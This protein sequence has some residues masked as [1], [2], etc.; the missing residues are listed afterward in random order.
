[1]GRE[2]DVSTPRTTVEKA[3]DALYTD[4]DTALDT[5]ASLLAADPAADAE[6]ARRGEEFVRRAWERGWQPA[7]VVRLARRD[8]AEEHVRL[9][10]A[11]IASET[12]RYERL[13]AR[14]AAQVADLDTRAWRADRFSYATAVLE[15]YRLLVRLPS[16]EPVGPVPGDSS[17][18]PPAVGE[19]RMLTRIRALLAK[20]EATG[21]PEEAEA[22]TA[23]A[24]ELMA[25]HSLDEAALASG[26]ATGDTPG[27]VRIGVDAPYEQAKA[28][29]L[30]AVATANHCR[31]V[32][33][34][35]YG[36]STV[37]GFEADLEAVEL[38]HTS[39]LVQGTA[40]MTRAEAEQRAG[41]R[42]R[43]KSFRQSFLLAYA[44][45]L[46]ARLA[47]TSR[48]VASETPTLLPALASREV[49]VTSHADAMF[50]QTRTT[51]VRAMWDE[52]GWTDGTT[53]ADRAGLGRHRPQVPPG[54]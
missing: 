53:A 13:P 15:L 37:V 24:Q 9:L 16:L 29:L 3:F 52:A 8:L 33:N 10:G 17:I 28:I 2:A 40:A 1:M 21:Y 30:D 26:A 50:P 4:D 18:P 11:L 22:L 36:F 12:A 42:K 51:R 49:A 6:L 25:R 5:A 32:W 45:R 46:G 35:T 39:L 44:N 41:G 38:L 31:A 48:R 23:K 27:A 34:E 47:T 19:P 20:A 54:H 43:T 14:W 7:D